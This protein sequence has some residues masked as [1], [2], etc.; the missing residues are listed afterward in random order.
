[1]NAADLRPRLAAEA[2]KALGLDRRTAPFADVAVSAAAAEEL[3]VV[4]IVAVGPS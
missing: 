2:M 4:V 1:V 3:P